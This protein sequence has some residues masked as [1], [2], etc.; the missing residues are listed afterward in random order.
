MSKQV[1]LVTGC[2]TGG[3]GYSLAKKFAEK[4]CLV[5]ATARRVEALEGLEAFDCEKETLDVTDK[6]SIDAVIKKIIDSHGHID[7]LVNN[8][9]SPAVGALLDI[10]MSVVEQCVNTNVYGVLAM[11]QAVGRHMAERGQGK[12]VNIGSVV[13]YG[14][15]P[16]AGIYS[17]SKAAVHSMSDVLRM[18]L[19]PFGIQVVVVA[20][21]AI[22]SNIGNAGSKTVHVPEDSLYTSVSKYIIGRANLSQGPGSTPTDVFA[23]H[24][25]KKVTQ[26]V[27]PR[28]VT[29]GATS[30]VFLLLFYLPLFIRELI[31]SK[32][33]GVNTIKRTKQ[34]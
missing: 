22:V 5:V 15:T 24:V 25:V 12:I 19:K 10:D 1:V 26:P 6:K 16:W 7:I 20:P 33:F 17:M 23:E 29:F 3:I 31:F 14:G 18:E 8:A 9:G 11:C 27:A 21:G 30:W 32:R 4:G 2:S 34:E 13:G 28:Y